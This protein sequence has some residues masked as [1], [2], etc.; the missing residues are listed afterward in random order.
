MNS[1]GKLT[2]SENAVR[3]EEVTAAQA[4]TRLAIQDPAVTPCQKQTPQQ[5]IW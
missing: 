4:A 1:C 5:S 2:S 3:A